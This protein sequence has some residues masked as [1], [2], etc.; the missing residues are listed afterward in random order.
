VAPRIEEILLERHVNVLFDDW[1]N[2]LRKQG[3]VEVLDP[4]FES[5]ETQRG[6]GKGGA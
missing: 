6:T 5:P 1:L 3:D 2:N 4:S